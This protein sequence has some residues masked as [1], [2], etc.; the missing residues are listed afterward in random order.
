[1]DLSNR[2]MNGH[3]LPSAYKERLDRFKKSDAE[4]EDMLEEII[5]NY[6]SL[7]QEYEEKCDDYNNEVESRRLWQNKARE[8][9]RA[10]TEFK[11]ASVSLFPTF[12]G[13]IMSPQRQLTDCAS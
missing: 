11:Q 2:N 12:L 13:I 8:G 9:A 3:I 7:K 1:M 10:L 5:R 4:R 6:E